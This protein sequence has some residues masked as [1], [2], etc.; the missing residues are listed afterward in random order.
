MTHDN[1]AVLVILCTLLEDEDFQIGAVDCLLQVI[2]RK[3]PLD[4][5]KFLLEWFDFKALKF[6]LNAAN[7]VSSKSLNEHNYLFLKKLTQVKK[8]DHI[9]LIG[10][11]WFTLLY[12]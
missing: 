9:N 2:S 7:N 10:L 11:F 6:M 5:R 8:L 3:G 4:E 12:S 1:N